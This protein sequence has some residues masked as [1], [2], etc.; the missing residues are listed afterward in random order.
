MKRRLYLA[1]GALLALVAAYIAGRYSAPTKVVETV[2]VETQIQTVTEWRDRIVYR[3]RTKVRTVVVE[4][5]APDGSS[6]TVTTTTQDNDIAGGSES[7]GSTDT[8][9]AQTS[10][11]KRVTETGRPGWRASVAAGW[12]PGALSLSPEVYEGRLERRLIGTLWL[13]AWARTDK[14]AGLSVGFEW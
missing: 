8:A 3:D 1:G 2:R 13:G 5:K 11:A 9:V 10:E 14:T 6:E 7:T 4:R 12:S